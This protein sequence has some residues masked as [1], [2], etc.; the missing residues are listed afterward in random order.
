MTLQD[1]FALMKT[2]SQ[3]FQ[4]YKVIKEIVLNG[5]W[6]ISQD[7]VNRLK[8]ALATQRASIS[9]LEKSLSDE[10]SLIEKV[11]TSQ[12]GLEYD[13]THISILGLSFGK[14]LF[15][16]GVF[17]VL[18]GMLLLL[19]GLLA[20]VRLISSEAKETKDLLNFSTHEL[21]EY[22][23]KSLEKQA[24]LSR[25]L[26]TERNRIASERTPIFTIKPMSTTQTIL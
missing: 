24:K 2:S 9:Q 18:L 16:S 10:R 4:D 25:E 22:K 17:I 1:R 8:G 11:R 5:V 15:V 19:G 7:S 13:S 14:T 23:K 20:K 3:T 12:Q 26:Q 6:K 21:E